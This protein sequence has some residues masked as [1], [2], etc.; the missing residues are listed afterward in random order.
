MLTVFETQDLICPR[1]LRKDYAYAETP[2][3]RTVA[4]LRQRSPKS[5]GSNRRAFCLGRA[6]DPHREF[7]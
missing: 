1:L 3:S 4:E 5:P 2:R 6:L 7:A